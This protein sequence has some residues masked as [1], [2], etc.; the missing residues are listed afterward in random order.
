MAL[1]CRTFSSVHLLI[2]YAFGAVIRIPY[3]DPDGGDED[4]RDGAR[5]AVKSGG[6]CAAK[7]TPPN[8][9]FALR[10]LQHPPRPAK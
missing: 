6:Y 9:R 7:N 8:K 4:N 5:S 3:G 1:S 2:D 10:V